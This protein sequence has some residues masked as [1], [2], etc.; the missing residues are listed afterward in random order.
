MSTDATNHSVQKPHRK[1][2]PFKKRRNNAPRDN[3]CNGALLI[4]KSRG[5][6]SFDVVEVVR[7]LLGVQR[8]GHCGTL[9]PLATGL[10]VLLLGEATKVAQFLTDEDKAYEGEIRLGVET[11]TDDAEGQVVREADP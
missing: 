8:V 7:E 9:D 10:L 5:M 1:R 6:T 2:R 11:D 3:A 4:D